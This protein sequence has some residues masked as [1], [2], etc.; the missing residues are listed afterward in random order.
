MILTML[1]LGS[2][3]DQTKTHGT[4]TVNYRRYYKTHGAVQVIDRS[5]CMTD[6]SKPVIGVSAH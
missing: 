5:K 2:N 3:D 4:A 1:A 6:G